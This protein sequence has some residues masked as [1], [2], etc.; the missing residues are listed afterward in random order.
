MRV[1]GFIVGVILLLPGACSLGF[2]ALSFGSSDSGTL[3]PLWIVCLLISA[4][5]VAMIV[6]AV[7]GPQ[8]PPA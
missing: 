4:G 5:G 2:M 1:L 3:A 7:R 6:R 8:P